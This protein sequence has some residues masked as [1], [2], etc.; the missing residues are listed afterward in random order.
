[1]N[2]GAGVHSF[3][4]PRVRRAPVSASGRTLDGAPVQITFER[5]TLVV[6]V[7]ASCDGC[8]DFIVGDLDELS[9]VAVVVLSAS[10]D[11]ADEWGGA[12][13]P[14]I[15]APRLLDDLD[16]LSAPFYVLILPE[17]P[18][19]VAEGSVFSPAQVAAEIAHHL[20]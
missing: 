18:N 14:V 15:V 9:R 20:D 6:S 1:M 11:G 5:P 19:V 13:R 4:R 2:D 17:G 3:D 16:V 8:R 7:K 10:A 12:V